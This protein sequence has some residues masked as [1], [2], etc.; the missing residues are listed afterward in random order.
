MVLPKFPLAAELN[1]NLLVM[2]LFEI[3]PMAEPNLTHFR[4]NL[5]CKRLVS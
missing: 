1:D 3:R 2:G 5:R 4:P